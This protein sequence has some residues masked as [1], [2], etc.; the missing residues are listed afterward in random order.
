[1]VKNIILIIAAIILGTMIGIVAVANSTEVR[2]ENCEPGTW[3]GGVKWEWKGEKWDYTGSDYVD[4]PEI[5]LKEVGA[6]VVDLEPGEYAITHYRP[7]MSGMT[8]DGR[9]WVLPAKVLDFVE[10][11][12]KDEPITLYF[13]CN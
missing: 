10:I 6:Q 7:H 13:G 1:M 4:V 5:E 2:F 9:I 12:V 11:E 3:V 8:E